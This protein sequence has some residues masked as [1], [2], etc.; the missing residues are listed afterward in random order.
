VLLAGLCLAGPFTLLPA[1]APAPTSAVHPPDISHWSPTGLGPT[2]RTAV[3]LPLAKAL[4]APQEH[5][6]GGPG[7]FEVSPTASDNR[8]IATISVSPDPDAVALDN[9]SNLIFVA[10][11]GGLSAGAVAVIDA[12]TNTVVRTIPQSPCPVGVAYV[13]PSGEVF[14]TGDGPSTVSVLNGTSASTLAL[15]KVGVDSTGIAYDPADGCLY[16]A[17]SGSNTVS[18]IDA[19]SRSVLKTIGVGSSPDAVTLDNAT[20][21]VYVTDDGSSNVTVIDT[22]VQAVV[23]T[24]TL[25][26]PSQ[27][28]AY[29]PLNGDLYATGELS[30][31]V[32]VV[33]GENETV[34]GTIPVGHDPLGIAFDPSNGALF[35]TNDHSG[36]VSVIDGATD[37]VVANWAVGLDPGA[38][39][40]DPWDDAIYVTNAGANTTSALRV[41]PSS[42]VTINVAG[43]P[44]GTPWHLLLGSMGRTVTAPNL[45]LVL[46][47]G[48]YPY[49]ISESTPNFLPSSA[50][51]PNGVIEVDGA[52]VNL[53]ITYQ[54][55]FLVTFRSTGLPSWA[56]Y[57]FLFNGILWANVSAVAPANTTLVNGS[58]PFTFVGTDWSY[59]YSVS[60]RAGGLTVAGA[61][62]TLTF[63]FSRAYPVTFHE[64]GLPA[65][66]A[67]SINISGPTSTSTTSTLTW[68]EANGTY[69]YGVVPPSGFGAVPPNGSFTVTGDGVRVNL[70]FFSTLVPLYGLWF[71]ESGLPL[72]IAWSVEIN[73]VPENGSTQP[74]FR[75]PEPN[76]TYEFAVPPVEGAG[77]RF[78]ATTV[79]GLSVTLVGAGASVAVTFTGLPIVQA[80]FRATERTV[81]TCPV[82]DWTVDLAATAQN[83][84]APYVFG[85]SFGDGSNGAGAVVNH[86]YG[87]DRGFTVNL[88]VTDA[89]GNETSL[90]EPLRPPKAGRCPSAGLI[91]GELKWIGLVAAVGVGVAAIAV[92]VLRGRGRG[93][94]PALRTGTGH[95]STEDDPGPSRPTG[96]SEVPTKRAGPDPPARTGVRDR[97]HEGADPW[98][99][100]GATLWRRAELRAHLDRHRC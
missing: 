17:N 27:G 1:P 93:P 52:S 13:P 90:G 87:S 23:D 80:S 66:S 41:G 16:V 29:D 88:T 60:P 51:R 62:A 24:V 28:I 34:V 18:V 32:S 39:V 15:I 78:S 94:K 99:E 76:G 3:P 58:Y 11:C 89:Q 44:G 36:N 85:W 49:E 72:G 75:I 8:T 33:E 25:P 45:T 55:T 84:T 47:N 82:S 83:G 71:N 79:P 22:S 10:S 65:G 96:G 73:G 95:H 67:W 21:A 63:S 43:L 81:S 6:E 14:V 2:P 92:I 30:D 57:S 54:E 46:P 26:A 20:G 100:L 40:Y 56:T 7:A 77:E 86:T 68:P 70:S 97:T 12:D 64:S 48:T 37:A 9:A 4:H 50:S 53:T 74:T 42:A 91:G 5:P 61:A 38:V 69:S 35:V 19:A 98:L 59:L 31:N